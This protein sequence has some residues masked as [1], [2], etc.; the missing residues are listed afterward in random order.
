[1][2]PRFGVLVLLLVGTLGIRPFV[3]SS[4]AEDAKCSPG[5]KLDA[6]GRHRELIARARTL[7]TRLARQRA[8]SDHY[9][10]AL[11]LGLKDENG[12]KITLL[13]DA[14]GYMFFIRDTNDPCNSSVFSDER[15]VIYDARPIQ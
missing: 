4:I 12:L 2:A 8:L 10:T 6:A 9:A 3:A 11:E 13:S 1:M 7:N 15:G 5:Q 14:N